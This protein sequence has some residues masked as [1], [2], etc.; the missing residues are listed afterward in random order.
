MKTLTVNGLPAPNPTICSQ[1]QPWAA[2]HAAVEARS[3]FLAST[4]SLSCFPVAREAGA[5]AQEWHDRGEPLAK[6]AAMFAAAIVE[7]LSH[8][9]A[10][11]SHLQQKGLPSL[12]R[13]RGLR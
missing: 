6:D 3:R 11:Q 7:I 5:V 2:Y 12:S 10:T 4:A 9:A 8:D 13:Q 1:D